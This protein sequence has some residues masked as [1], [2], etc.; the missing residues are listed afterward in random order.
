MRSR[1][2]FSWSVAEN[3]QVRLIAIL[4]SSDNIIVTEEGSGSAILLDPQI[5]CCPSSQYPWFVFYAT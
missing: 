2:V 4:M 1:L 3:L 5:M